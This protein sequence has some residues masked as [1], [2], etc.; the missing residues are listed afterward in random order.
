[1]KRI[2]GAMLALA[3]LCLL[4]YPESLLPKTSP[5][6]TCRPKCWSS[7]ASTPSR[8]TQEGA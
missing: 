1:M 4:E 7:R 5:W 2:A 6:G 8:A 3:L